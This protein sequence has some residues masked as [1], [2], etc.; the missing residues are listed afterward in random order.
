[1]KYNFKFECEICTFLEDFLTL[2]DVK[3][4][5]VQFTE[6]FE[7]WVDNTFDSVEDSNCYIDI[8][9]HACRLICTDENGK[10][11]FNVAINKDGKI[12]DGIKNEVV[13]TKASEKYF[14]I[15]GPSYSEWA[16]G[17]NTYDEESLHDVTP[18]L[19]LST[20]PELGKIKLHLCNWHGRLLL[21]PYKF[22]Y[23]GQMIYLDD[24]GN[25]SFVLLEA[26]RVYENNCDWDVPMFKFGKLFY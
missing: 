10:E 12:C 16:T 25:D 5:P 23:D 22:E 15:E 14:E 9:Q 3:D 2:Q 8:E 6:A 21:I 4:I 17:K 19:E 20:A 18:Y 24:H 7:P 1:M 11:I 26:Y 13:I